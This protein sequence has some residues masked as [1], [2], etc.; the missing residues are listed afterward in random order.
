MTGSALRR[1]YG[2]PGFRLPAELR[3][4]ERLQSDDEVGVQV[5]DDIRPAP[6]GKYRP[7]IGTLA[8]KLRG[9]GQ[10]GG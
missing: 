8:A 9:F 7:V 2:R 6:S 5:V 4:S 1:C 10:D 3:R